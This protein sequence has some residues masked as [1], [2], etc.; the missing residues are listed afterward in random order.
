MIEDFNEFRRYYYENM[1]GFL[2]STELYTIFELALA[3]LELREEYTCIVIALVM[4]GMDWESSF[5]DI[6]QAW[7][8]VNRDKMWWEQP[9]NGAYYQHRK[10]A[11]SG[12]LQE[13]GKI[14]GAVY[15]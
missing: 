6:K 15:A 13:F 12:M 1:G 2:T 3:K 10:N 9:L 5:H 7:T 8:Y 4:D 11:L 14:N